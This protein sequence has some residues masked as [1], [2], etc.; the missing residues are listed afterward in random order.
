MKAPAIY[1]CPICGHGGSENGECPQCQVPL[2]EYGKEEQAEYQAYPQIQS[3][4]R[5]MSEYKW[6]V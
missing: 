2:V 5:S 1:L 3:T 4:M 6:Y